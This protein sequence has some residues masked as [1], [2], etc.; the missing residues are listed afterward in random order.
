MQ[1]TSALM[2]RALMQRALPIILSNSLPFFP[3]IPSIICELFF[4]ISTAAQGLAKVSQL[5]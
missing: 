4:L 1:M 5:L 2:Q 3:S